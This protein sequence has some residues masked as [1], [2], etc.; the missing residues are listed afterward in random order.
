MK[1]V[2]SFA[3]LTKLRGEV[4]ACK[5][6]LRDNRRYFAG[7]FP[8]LD[9]TV[10]TELSRILG[11]RKFSDQE[12]PQI[13]LESNEDF[14]SQLNSMPLDKLS[15]YVDSEASALKGAESNLKHQRSKGLHKAAA[16]TQ[17]F[18]MA[19][20][21]FLKAYSGIVQIV[22]TVD[23]QYGGVA[24]ATLSLLFAVSTIKE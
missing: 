1:L 10:T 15:S 24:C 14:L 21:G 13:Q 6:V 18:L 7:L 17:N 2:S 8:R 11:D 5:D 16:K 19:F 4:A 12:Q 3:R 22:Q 20:D 9:K 23:A